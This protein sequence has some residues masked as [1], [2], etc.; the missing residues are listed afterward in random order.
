MYETFF[1]FSEK[2]FNLTPDPKYLYLSPR[3]TEAAAHLEFGR[4]ER[5][6]FIV[7]TGE[8]GTGKTTLAR[9]FLSHLPTTTATAVILY[10]ALSALELLRSI[11]DDLHITASGPS[12][13]DQVDALHRFL[14]AARH[15]GRD[16]VL[17][18]DEAQDLR[19]DVLEQVRLLSNLE[20]DT[21]KLIQII[22][23]GQSELRELLARPSLRQLA[24]RIT[25]RYHLEPLSRSE[26]EEYV[27]HRLHVAGG[28]G[29]V[30]FTTGALNGLHSLSRGIPRL[31]NLIADRSLLAGF[32]R[33]SREIHA[34]MV[35]EAAKEVLEKTVKPRT[36]RSWTTLGTAA[37]L[38]TLVLAGLA[39]PRTLRAPDA[40]PPPEAGVPT[41]LPATPTPD[42]SPSPVAAP[43]DTRLTERLATLPRVPS[44]EAAFQRVTELWGVSPLERTPVRTHFEQ[45]RKFD[46]PVVL[47]LFHPARR[48]TA[49]VA[50]LGLGEA[51]AEVALGGDPPLR[52]S[53]SAL[54]R[55]WT[56]DAVVV[57]RDSLA[58]GRARQPARTERFVREALW[59]L[60]YP[61]QPDLGA[62]VG[63]FQREVDLLPDGV[64]GHRTLMAIYGA[65]AQPRP[66]LKTGGKVS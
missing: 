27:R 58:L 43:D 11:L 66:R 50:L 12:L 39:L 46:F 65:S 35:R 49:F 51:E 48:D 29:K 60:G 20:T 64:V 37:A 1:G 16:V 10:P 28:Q 32:V 19:A 31:V 22:L 45:L 4:R 26:T 36:S 40:G 61:P 55:Y 18:I 34:G 15:E 47:E 56:K 59:Q 5:G 23:M 53:A 30:S 62:L 63:R 14:L 13:K 57:W 2:P 44:R 6:G 54:E 42:P 41:P 33:S 38:V 17:L 8:V 9:H 24:Q 3:H 21:E 7:I 52:V 25:A